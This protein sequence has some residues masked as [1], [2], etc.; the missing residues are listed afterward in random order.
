MSNILQF[1]GIEYLMDIIY[2]KANLNI[3]QLNTEWSISELFIFMGIVYAVKSPTEVQSFADMLEKNF[4]EHFQPYLVMFI[5][6]LLH[7]IRGLRRNGSCETEPISRLI[8]GIRWSDFR[9]VEKYWNCPFLN[10]G[11]FH[12][13]IFGM[14]TD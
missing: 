10:V 13:W 2:K 3:W 4:S 6:T 12:I 5:W 11:A 9:C 1:I 7:L 14:Q 8:A